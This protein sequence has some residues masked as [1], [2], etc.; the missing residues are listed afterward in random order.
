MYEPRTFVN[1][2]H[3]GTLGF[4]F[5]EALG[6]KAGN[7][8]KAVVSITGD[9]GFMFGVQDLATAVQYGINVVTI[10]F[11]NNAYGNVLRDQQTLFE[12]ACAW[13]RTAQ[14]RL[15]Q[16]GA[17]LRHVGLPRVHA[18]GPQG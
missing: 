5:A 7:P 9:G 10:V 16:T 15:R 11:N 17:Q 8:D 1:C 2:G 3:Q 12:G 18:R 4:G 14:S 13:F 6:V